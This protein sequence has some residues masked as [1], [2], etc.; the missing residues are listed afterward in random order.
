[1]LDII[2]ELTYVSRKRP[3]AR[4]EVKVLLQAQSTAITEMLDT[5]FHQSRPPSSMTASAFLL[6]FFASAV[7]AQ[8]DHQDDIGQAPMQSS[9]SGEEPFG[10]T[11]RIAIIGAGIAG[12]SAAHHLH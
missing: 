5:F 7:I 9:A 1:M 4:L 6:F 10:H 11:P 8:L 12:A 3:I 2:P